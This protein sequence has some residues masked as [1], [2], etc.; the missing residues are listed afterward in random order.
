M[1]ILH[2]TALRVYG[3][4]ILEKSGNAHETI[5]AQEKKGEKDFV[6]KMGSLVEE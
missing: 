5:T 6:K 3:V 1:S 2:A 4:Y